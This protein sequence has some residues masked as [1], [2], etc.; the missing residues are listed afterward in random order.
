MNKK[1][2]NAD[3]WLWLTVPIT[4]LLAIAAGCGVFISGLYR[5]NPSLVAQAMGQDAI[6]LMIAIPALIIHG[7]ND[8]IVPLAEGK[9]LY[10]S[11]GA[12]DK[13]LLIIPGADHNDI[14]YRGMELYLEALKEFVD[15]H[16]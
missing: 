8:S 5:D 7:Q 11:I 9:R 16:R 6:T 1:T 12:G 14:F 13:R 10:D 15:A 2:R 3:V 4:I